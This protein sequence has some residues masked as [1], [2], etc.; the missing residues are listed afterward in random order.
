MSGFSTAVAM[1][2]TATSASFTKLQRQRS[3]KRAE[4]PLD[5]S[6]LWVEMLD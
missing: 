2:R 5:F 3:E 4:Y 6:A 1:T